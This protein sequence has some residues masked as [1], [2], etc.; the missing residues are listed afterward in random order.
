M[1]KTKI[2]AEIIRVCTKCEY[3]WKS[4]TAFTGES[5][6]KCPKCRALVPGDSFYKPGG[7]YEPKKPVQRTFA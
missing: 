1:S 5:T 4:V 6:T 3:E 2:K 7:K